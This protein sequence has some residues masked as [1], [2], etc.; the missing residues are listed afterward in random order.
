MDFY[1]KLLL[2]I[3]DIPTDQSFIVSQAYGEGWSAIP[4]KDKILISLKLKDEAIAGK[5]P[6]VKYCG[7]IEGRTHKHKL[8][9][10]C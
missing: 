3:K 9:R 6:N 10:K 2:R 5:I 1:H 4:A 8:Y 7:L